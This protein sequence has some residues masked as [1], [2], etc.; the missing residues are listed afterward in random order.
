MGWLVKFLI[1]KVVRCLRKV[2]LVLKVNNILMNDIL[3]RLVC[4]IL[5]LNREHLVPV[6]T[7]KLSYGLS[8]ILIN[9]VCVNFVTILCNLRIF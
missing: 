4:W 8:R 9:V 1:N 2:N 6:Y 3:V 5:L 7:Q